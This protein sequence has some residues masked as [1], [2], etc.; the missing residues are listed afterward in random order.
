MNT[1]GY[2]ATSPVIEGIE[3]IFG[4]LFLAH[5]TGREHEVNVV[6]ELRVGGL[7]G[8]QV[9]ALYLVYVKYFRLKLNS[10]TTFA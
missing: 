7:K 2:D 4:G 3:L 9:L 10:T 5:T 6:A 8:A 1:R